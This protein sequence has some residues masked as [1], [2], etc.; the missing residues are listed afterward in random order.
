M[1]HFTA[2]RYGSRPICAKIYLA[3][4]RAG[5]KGLIM[6]IVPVALVLL[7]ALVGCAATVNE[8]EATPPIV[9]LRL[10]GSPQEAAQCVIQ[11]V[12]SLGWVTSMRNF[13][14][15]VQIVWT[16]RPNEPIAT[17]D[18][19]PVEERFTIAQMRVNLH[20]VHDP[21]HIAAV[22]RERLRPCM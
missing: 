11:S 21:A 8:I 4:L 16:I 14:S 2:R 17:F 12:E 3:V 13:G 10:K 1:T 15:H 6:R 22:W 7:L 19:A 18:L 5:E 20:T 9:T